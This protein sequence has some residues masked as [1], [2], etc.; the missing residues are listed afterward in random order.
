MLQRFI[1][2]VISSMLLII[3]VMSIACNKNNPADSNPVLSPR[4]TMSTNISSVFV[5]DTLF[6]DVEVTDHQGVIVSDPEIE[7]EVSDNSIAKVT[8]NG[9]V[10]GLAPGNVN[11]TIKWSEVELKKELRVAE[12]SIISIP[13]GLNLKPE[14][15]LIVGPDGSSNADDEGRFFFPILSEGQDRSPIFATDKNDDVVMMSYTSRGAAELE[16]QL[17]TKTTAFAL[18]MNDFRLLE[19]TPAEIFSI[20]VNLSNDNRIDQ[21][22]AMMELIFSEGTSNPLD[23]I[24]INEFAFNIFTDEFSKIAGNVQNASKALIQGGPTVTEPND[25]CDNSD[26]LVTNPRYLVYKFHLNYEQTVHNPDW[27]E[28]TYLIPRTHFGLLGHDLEKIQMS[29]PKDKRFDTQFEYFPELTGF[30][31]LWSLF[32]T[33]WGG[34]IPFSDLKDRKPGQWEKTFNNVN[35]AQIRTVIIQAFN[36]Y[37]STGSVTSAIAFIFRDILKRPLEWITFVGEMYLNSVL[38]ANLEEFKKFLF[39][40][41]KSFAKKINA[42]SAI[43]DLA[44]GTTNMV[45]MIKDIN[46]H[47][48]DV[49]EKEMYVNIDSYLADAKDVGEVNIQV[50]NSDG[51]PMENAWVWLE[52]T[53]DPNCPAFKP[54]PADASGFMQ[55]EGIVAGKRKI[56]VNHRRLSNEDDS[57]TETITINALQSNDITVKF[58]AAEVDGVTEESY[59]TGFVNEITITGKNLF[60]VTKVDYNLNGY[61]SGVWLYDYH[62]NELGNSITIEHGVP[63]NLG[64]GTASYILQTAVRGDIEFEVEYYQ[65]YVGLGESSWDWYEGGGLHNCELTISNTF[66]MRWRYPNVT[67]SGEYTLEDNHI[68]FNKT[69]VYLGNTYT[70]L[71]IGTVNEKLDT[72]SGTYT[73]EVNGVPSNSD[74]VTFTA[75]RR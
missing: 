8:S 21:L 39:S 24:T 58:E 28:G 43:Y 3:L 67:H 64:E 33:V 35:K 40:L 61:K 11:L 37:K 52:K 1:E 41:S 55:Y 49:F 27:P 60:A 30:D 26:I 15:I 48:N 7:L 34:I 5:G 4:I 53:P 19:L 42:I 12:A 20:E 13:Q 70:Q 56:K 66:Q 16:G 59:P 38:K 9:N 23:D 50:L 18:V 44:M 32:S 62:Q 65:P 10:L 73:R 51:T 6:V 29:M 57:T 22:A 63:Y 75:V 68:E 46:Q 2:F 71:C 74:P 31:F 17:N 25:P 14:E 72:I 47:D 54:F 45:Y 69:Q 36:E